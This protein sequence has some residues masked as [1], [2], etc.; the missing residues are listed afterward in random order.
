MGD[1]FTIDVQGA[2]SL[3]ES[4]EFGFGQRDAA[5][6]DDRMRMAFVLDGYEEQVGVVLRQDGARIVGEIQHT[7]SAADAP[8]DAVARQVA[9]ILSL[10]HDGTAFA[11]VGRRD[12]V[13]A[14][15]QA[16]APGL[17]PPLFHS[18]FEAAAWSVLSARRPARQMSRVRDQLAGAHGARFDL[19]G[20]AMP[21]FPTPAQLLAVDGFPGV[22]AQHMERLHG[23]ARAAQAGTLDASRLLRMGPEAA[24]STVR[25][26]RGIG[27]F[28][29]SL[30]VVRG[31]G[32]ADVLSPEEPRVRTLVGELYGF[33]RAV[34]PVELEEIADAWRP[35]RTWAAVLV[36][37]AAERQRVA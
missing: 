10:D 23:V 27:P 6:F 34:T 12:P 35:L 2:F 7:G 5:S 1:S 33:G 31:T 20:R 15:L 13:I 36:R 37:A 28:Y 14:G 19:D 18:P 24:L 17:R 3:R 9:R 25:R 30:I 11:D 21:A 8:V 16:V 4:A 26:I 29:A 32:F 22:P